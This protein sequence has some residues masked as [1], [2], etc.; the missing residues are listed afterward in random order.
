MYEDLIQEFLDQKS[1][2]VVGS[3]RNE[4]K[5]AYKINHFLSNVTHERGEE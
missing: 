2:A 4:T 5:Y 3:F 1:F